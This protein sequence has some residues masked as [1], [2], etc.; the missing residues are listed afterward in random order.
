MN[1]LYYITHFGYNALPAAFFKWKYRQ[2]KQ[3]EQRCDQQQLQQRLDYYFKVSK[4]FELPDQAVA[5]GDFKRGKGTGYYLDLKEFL[6]YFSPATRF[7]YQFGDDT[8]VNPYPTLFKARPIGDDNA[9]SILFKLNKRRHF[10]WV[11]DRRPF[12]TKKDMLVWRGGAYRPL[13]RQI[14]ERLWNHPLCNVGQ[15]NKPA[16]DVPW[17]KQRLSISEQLQYKFIL[18]LEGNDVATNLKWAMSS[19]SLCLMPRPRYEIW[20]MEGTLQP[21]VHYVELHPTCDDLGEQLDYYARHPAQAEAII[22]N[23]HD[24]VARFQDPRMEDLL[25]LKVLERYAL[26][27]GQADQTKFGDLLS[28]C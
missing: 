19:N 15:T 23:A 6:H 25:C 16:E 18:C 27:S 9:N 20:F 11:N 8:H 7:A 14:V 5:V 4:S 3:F 24:H 17:Q 26:L 22:R 2:L 28:L 12:A 13:R 21:G 10:H 1:A